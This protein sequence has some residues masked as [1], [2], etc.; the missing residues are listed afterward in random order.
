MKKLVFILVLITFALNLKAQNI[1]ITFS[2]SGASTTVDS[3]NVK[4]LTQ[5]TSLTLNGS[6]IL[7]LVT[8][9][10]T[11]N[12]NKNEGKL[13]VFPNPFKENT[14]IGFAVNN[15]GD[16]TI[17]VFDISSKLILTQNLFLN[18][19][20][21]T[22]EISG[23]NNGIYFVCLSSKGMQLTSRLTAIEGSGKKPSLRYTGCFKTEPNSSMV[24]KSSKNTIQMSYNSG[25]VILF[26]AYSGTYTTVTSLVPTGNQNLNSVFTPCTDGNGYTYPVVAI[27]SQVWMAENLRAT[28]YKDGTDIPL[29]TDNTAWSNLTTGAYC[30]YN[31]NTANGG[32]Y[33]FLY[34]WYAVNTLNLC[35]TGWH[36]PTYSNLL[37]LNSYLGGEI[38]A[39]GKLKETGTLHWQNPNFGATNETGFTSLPGGVRTNLGV[40]SGYQQSGYWWSATQD[41]VTYAYGFQMSYS[42]GNNYLPSDYKTEGWSV[43]CIKD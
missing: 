42:S 16:A 24:N 29:I 32:I 35:P 3:V 8:V 40:F 7:E 13:S 9:V 36:V 17:D 38:L 30:M 4:N 12:I 33:G 31:N 10:A 11:E 2:G 28:K 20:I 43:R 37:S 22:F 41:D 15:P 26:T 27:G 18:T 14:T 1:Q 5:S 19:G 23:L 39:G 25:D 34:N 6:D 21:H